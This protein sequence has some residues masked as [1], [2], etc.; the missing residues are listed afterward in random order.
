EARGSGG[1][2]ANYGVLTVSGGRVHLAKV[3]RDP[4]LDEAGTNPK[5]L[6]RPP[7]YLARYGKFEPAQTWENVTMSPDFPSVAEVMAQLYPQ[8]GGVP[9]DGVIRL[10]PVALSGLLRLTGPVRVPGL[11]VTLDTHN[12]V[13]FLLRDEFTL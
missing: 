9:I 1:L 8:S 7:D 3:G 12:A 10:D 11:P 13:R 5:R 2:M 4:D 6:T